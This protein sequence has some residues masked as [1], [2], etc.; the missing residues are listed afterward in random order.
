MRLLSIHYSLLNCFLSGKGK[1]S[2]FQKLSSQRSLKCC[3]DI[4]Q[5][6]TISAN[7]IAEV[8]QMVCLLYGST[9][10]L[11]NDARYQLFLSLNGAEQS[12]PPTSNALH[13]HLLRS[14]YQASIWRAASQQFIKPPSPL[15]HG[16]KHGEYGLEVV[17]MTEPSAPPEVLKTMFCSCKVSGCEGARCSCQKTKLSCTSLCKCTN[18]NNNVPDVSTTLDLDDASESDSDM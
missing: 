17:W 9:A 15:E 5:S 13:Q 18:C 16:W 10:S 3:A 2:V 7:L 14:N 1:K 4:G 6:F 11:V 8:E 12:L